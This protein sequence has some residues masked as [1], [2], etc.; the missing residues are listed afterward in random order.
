[1]CACI[2]NTHR[3]SDDYSDYD[4]DSTYG[5]TLVVTPVTDAA[6]VEEAVIEYD[7]EFYTRLSRANE[8]MTQLEDCIRYDNYSDWDR[9]ADD[10]NDVY[11]QLMDSFDSSDYDQS[12]ALERLNMRISRLNDSYSAATAVAVPD[13]TQLYY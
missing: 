7:S 2:P 1:M 11:S 8:I 13:S 12:E 5:D 3:Y 4:Y 10:F 9:L 6:S